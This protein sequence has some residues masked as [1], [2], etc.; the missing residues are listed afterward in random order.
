MFT[1]TEVKPDIVQNLWH[2]LLIANL[3]LIVIEP[4]SRSTHAALQ[5]QLRHKS[6]VPESTRLDGDHH[7]K[8][9]SRHMSSSSPFPT[10]QATFSQTTKRNLQRSHI[11][12][13]E[14]LS[15]ISLYPP[16]SLSFA[17]HASLTPS[18]TSQLK[19]SAAR[20]ACLFWLFLRSPSVSLSE[21]RRLLPFLYLFSFL[22]RWSTQASFMP[23]PPP[24]CTHAPRS[25]RP[26]P[27][28][29]RL[30]VWPIWLETRQVSRVRSPSLS[31]SSV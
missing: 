28:K 14:P 21:C 18:M 3:N 17:L 22:F 11:Y 31:F 9:A 20:V 12:S 30:W 26:L 16:S 5:E 6:R 1:T 25:R 27:A 15:L 10:N 2:A 4:P 19:P 24:R 23:P 29:I 8:R 13:P 7:Q